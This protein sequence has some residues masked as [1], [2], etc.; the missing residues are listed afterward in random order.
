MLQYSISVTRCL[1]SHHIVWYEKSISP[2]HEI[3]KYF[4]PSIL[5]LGTIL[6]LSLPAEALATPPDIILSEVSIAGEKS[7]DEYIELYNTSDVALDLSG[8]QLRRKTQSGNESS[9]KVFPS[10]SIIPAHGY[11]LWAN[12]DG[13]FKSPFADTET[14]SSA[15]ASDN[16]VGL[17]SQSGSDGILLDSLSWGKGALFSPD[18]IA[19]PNPVK[20]TALTRDL[21]TLSWTPTTTLTPTNSRG[22]AWTTPTPDPTPLPAEGTVSV[23]FNEVFANPKG[24]EAEGE[25]IELY[26]NSLTEVILDG[27]HIKDASQT[28]DYTFPKGTVIEAQGYFLLTRGASKISLNNSNETLTLSTSVGTLLDSM[29]YTKTKENISLNYTPTSWRGGP[30]TPGAPNQLNTL[31]E[32][33]ERVPK[34]GYRGVPV[35]MNARGEDADGDALKYTWDFG[36]NHKSYKR[37]TT[38]T[39]EKNGTHAITLTTTDGSDDTVETFSIK[40]E[41]FPEANVRITSFMPNPAGNDSENEWLIIENRGKK[42]VDL[43]GYGIATGWKKL[44]N[45]P[46]RESFVIKPKS[47]AKLTRTFSLFTLPNQKGKIELRSPDGKTIQD[48]KYKLEKSIPENAVYS[49]EKGKR[50]EWHEAP[51]TEIPD[52]PPPTSE[53]KEAVIDDPISELPEL[54]PQE[55]TSEP[56][57]LGVST[58]NI[59]SHHRAYLKLLNYG[60]TVELPDEII[61]AFPE[62]TETLPRTREHYALAF[63]KEILS[64]INTTLNNWQNE[65]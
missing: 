64:D 17:F 3:M 31:P 45:H 48:I 26:N 36:D 5:A 30:P 46:I 54:P 12:S 52:T 63:A 51:D 58:E 1:V 6:A 13:L 8:K 49:K 41:S 28:G 60:T 32:T 2:F 23:R 15:L 43:Q 9:I 27:L 10:Q 19:L 7:S 34:K 24:D 55:E 25:F 29:N 20:N 21:A 35:S 44:S 38:H 50:W 65:E 22:D 56:E 4:L 61:L 62:E 39:Y 40:I 11:F 18:D 57:V 42:S 47:E 16:S 37:E 59:A 53:P 14:S 33:K